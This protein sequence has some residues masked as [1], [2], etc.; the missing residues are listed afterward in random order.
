MREKERETER[1]KQT[2][3]ITSGTGQALHPLEQTLPGLRR[4]GRRAGGPRAGS[5]IETEIAADGLRRS[6]GRR[7]R[8][9]RLSR[10]RNRAR[11][12][13]QRSIRHRLIR[14]RRV[15]PAHGGQPRIGVGLIV[16]LRAQVPW[17]EPGRQAIVVAVTVTIGRVAARFSHAFF[18]AHFKCTSITQPN[19]GAGGMRSVKMTST[20]ISSR[21]LIGRRYMRICRWLSR[22]HNPPCDDRGAILAR[23]DAFVFQSVT[24]NLLF[25]FFYSGELVPHR[26]KWAPRRE[27]QRGIRHIVA[28]LRHRSPHSRTCVC[29]YSSWVKAGDERRDIADEGGGRERRY[30]M[31]TLPGVRQH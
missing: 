21:S 20:M 7:A 26:V 3:L 11:L 8:Y 28:H 13:L 4:R 29:D 18:A 31:L 30:V 2:C 10:G 1:M 14:L 5:Q 27:Q 23:S 24:R 12:G 22:C 19:A 16:E 15:L 9:R 6:L 25:S 17:R